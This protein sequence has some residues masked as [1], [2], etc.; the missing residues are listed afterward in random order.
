M[1]L[2]LHERGLIIGK[3]NNDITCQ[4]RKLEFSLL[5]NEVQRRLQKLPLS[6]INYESKHPK[7]SF[8]NVLTFHI[9]IFG[10]F[11]HDLAYMDAGENPVSGF[12]LISKSL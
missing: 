6:I 4:S 12:M 3:A 5:I 9:H 1:R 2:M 7:T 11:V 10:Q 8:H